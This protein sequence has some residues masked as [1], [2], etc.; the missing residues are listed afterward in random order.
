MSE[1]K[2]VNVKETSHRSWGVQ[3][4]GCNGTS[5]KASAE[6]GEGKHFNIE[7]RTSGPGEPTS[8][9]DIQM[10]ADDFSAWSAKVLAKLRGDGWR[11]KR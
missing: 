4:D 9:I 1:K 11:P 5:L 3:V 2:A 8:T 7:A 6:N 10:S